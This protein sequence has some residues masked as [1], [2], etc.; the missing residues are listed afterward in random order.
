MFRVVSFIHS[1]ACLAHRLTRS[2]TVSASFRA[3]FLPP[4]VV[5][6]VEFHVEQSA[7]VP[8]AKDDHRLQ[9]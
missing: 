2:I 4:L 8:Q 1:V 9:W 5:F 3:L 6:H 7:G